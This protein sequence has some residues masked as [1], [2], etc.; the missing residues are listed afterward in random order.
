MNTINIQMPY[1]TVVWKL[2][3]RQ[4]LRKLRY[5]QITGQ[6]TNQNYNEDEV[7]ADSVWKMF[8]T[9]QFRIF[10]LHIFWRLKYAKQ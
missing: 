9:I 5:H 4:T 7:K 3:Y 1:Q 10:Y 6:L 8:A 2:I